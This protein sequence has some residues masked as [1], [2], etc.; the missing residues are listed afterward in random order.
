VLN[1]YWFVCVLLQAGDK[2]V[3][4]DPVLVELAKKHNKSVAQVVLRWH[5]Q[6][7]VSVIPKSVTEQRIIENNRVWDFSLTHDE[8][9][10]IGR[11]NCGLRL[12]AWRATAVDPE[13]PFKDELP[14]GFTKE[15]APSATK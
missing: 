5:L 3:F 7:N 11:L 2:S 6:R 13:Y 10:D 14:R 15:K 4:T 1:T 8:M 9:S 12:G